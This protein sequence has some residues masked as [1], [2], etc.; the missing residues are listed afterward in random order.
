MSKYWVQ[1]PQKGIIGPI[2]AETVRDLT[3][4]GAIEADA[5]LSRDNAPFLP[6]GAFAEFETSISGLKP[7]PAPTHSGDVSSGSFFRVFHRYYR[8]EANGLLVVQDG[9]FR[10]DIYIEF[11]DPV[12][13]ASNI[14]KER[15]GQF[16]VARDKITREQLQQGLDLMQQEN[17]RLGE[18]LVK[19]R[20]LAPQEL[21]AELREQQLERLVDLCTWEYGTYRYYEGRRYEGER[22]QLDLQT[23]ELVVTAA[24]RMPEKT[25]LLRLGKHLHQRVRHVANPTS[26]RCGL[27]FSQEERR[28]QEVINGEHTAVEFI[29]AVGARA[30]SRRAALTVLYLLWELR[31]AEFSAS[32]E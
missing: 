12:F 32:V 3:A 27:L 29:T 17:R 20:A 16:L 2:S 19:I 25:A 13:V 14:V 26:E 7:G 22:Q 5:L 31:A 21:R 8:S 11:G 23:P 30:G 24:R 1:N 15:F 9:T 18:L 4:S 6:L 10:K 28:A